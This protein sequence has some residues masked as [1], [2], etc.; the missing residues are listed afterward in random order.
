MDNNLKDVDTRRNFAALNDTK[1]VLKAFNS[2]LQGHDNDE[3]TISRIEYGSNRVT[4]KNRYV[5]LKRLYH[6]FVNVFTVAL[7]L[8]AAFSYFVAQGGLPPLVVISILILVSGLL[9][10]VQETRND[11]AASQLVSMVTTIITVR[12]ENIEVEMDARELVVG[13]IL[14]LDTGDMIPADARIVSSAN[15]KVDESALTGESGGVDKISDKSSIDENELERKN[16]VYMGTN[17]IGGS[18]EAVVVAVGNDTLFGSIADSISR[19]KSATT[20]N[21][22]SKA[23]LS[24]LLKIMIVLIPIVFVITI[25]KGDVTVSESLILAVALAIGLMPEMLP[26]VISA[27][28][29]KGA[30]DMYKQKIIVKDMPSIQNL[31]A[32]DVLCT[33]KTGTLTQNKI[34]VES[35][36]D[37]YG[38]K[39]AFIS[40]LAYLNSWNLTSGTNQIDWA[41]DEYA[42]E[43]GITEE[44]EEYEFTGDI[45]FDFVRRRAT[46]SIKKDGVRY[47]IVKGAIQEMLQISENYLESGTINPLDIRIINDIMGLTEWNS[48]KGMRQLGVAYK[49]ISDDEELSLESENG[50]IFAG[51][52]TFM[53]PVKISAKDAITDFYEHGIGVKV[54]TGDNEFVTRTVCESI[55]L[56]TEEVLVGN[57][58]DSMSDEELRVKVENT[59][60]FARLTPENKRRIVAALGD[61]GHTVGMLG[62]GI[63]DV[64]A[65]KSADVSISV[66]AGMDIAKETADMILLDKNLGVIKD[67][68]VEGRKVYANTIKYVKMTS[69][70]NFGYMLS[71]IIATIFFPFEP[72]TSMQILV[73]NLIVDVSCIAI[74]WDRVE[75]YYVK[76]PR[77]WDSISLRRTF[78]HFGPATTVTDIVTFLILTAFICPLI[79][80]PFTDDPAL[81]AAIFQ[82]CWFVENFWMQVQIIH[83]IRTPKVPFLQ[84]R[85]SGIMILA[86]VLALVTG[87]VLPFTPIGSFLGM[88]PIPW[89]FA[90]LLP[91]LGLLYT[92]LALTVKKYYLGKY[93][94]LL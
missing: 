53:D 38:N 81:Y 1:A 62:D 18:A 79:V 35:C 48:S 68:V 67:G 22:G 76:Q 64:M 20:Y 49:P 16:M 90:M 12:R 3:V 92:V 55:N 72:M 7:A 6:A 66:D 82:T 23:V 73:F 57:Q 28:L 80:G 52:I 39:S 77:M 47:L 74:P 32:M 30:V 31:G 34:S 89:E 84:S 86:S 51:F 60:I 42:D 40:K 27:N 83:I 70:A 45:P 75:D 59:D 8:L 63:N 17:V 37:V 4:N 14:I 71:L 2:R 94:E 21:K 44:C 33:D 25:L 46:V 19:K 9:T 91:L 56:P 5:V 10:F 43:E 24:V 13:D 54:L 58:I 93:E 69:S 11:K 15:L 65:M 29:A 26:T 78:T 36:Q 50:L 41:I 87:T 88:V 61:N 85:A